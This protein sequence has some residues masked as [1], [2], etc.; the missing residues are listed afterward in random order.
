MNKPK[1]LIEV[2]LPLEAINRE[3]AREKSIRH[4][5]PSTLHLWWARRPL[6]A[7]RAVIFAQMV[8]DP[9]SRPDLFQTEEKQNKER[10]RLFKII[11]DLVKWE[12]MNDEDLLEKARAEI[13]KYAPNGEPPPLFDPFAGGGSIPLEAQRLGLKALAGDLNPVAVLINKA[14][15]EIPPRFAGRPPV[16]PEARQKGKLKVWKGAAGLAEDV[17]YYGRWMREEAERRIGHFYPKYKITEELLEKRPDLKKQGLK[18]GD[19]LTVIAWLWART[20][21]CPNPACGA[22]MP[23]ISSLW[24]S[25][26]K[27]K[28]AWVEP[29]VDRSTAPPTIRFE[30]RTEGK[31]PNSPKIGR[32]AKFKCVAC[33]QISED[34]HI[35]KEFQEKRNEVQLMAVVAEGVRGRIYLPPTED[36][37]KIAESVNPTWKP[38]IEMNQDCKDLISGRGYGFK[39]WY[40]IFTDRQLTALTTFSD[41][42]AEARE[43]VRGDAVAAGLPD[44]GKPLREGGCGATAYA[45][46]VAT[47]LAL[48]IDRIADRNSSICSWDSSRD[49]VRNTFARQALP[50]TWDFAEANP[51]SSSTGNFLGAVEWVA[52]VIERIPAE[53]GGLAQQTDATSVKNESS[54]LVISVDPPYYDNIGY[55]DLSDFFYIW[56]RR[57][58]KEIYP[59]LFG[60]LLTPKSDELVATPYRFGGD[61]EKARKFFEEGLRRAFENLRRATHPDYPV[62]IYYAFKQ[63]ETDGNGENVST[64][65]ETM[66]ESLI[67]AGFQITGTWPLRT[68]LGN[69]TVAM[70][71]NALASSIV[72]VCR[73]RAENAPVT[74]RR[75]FLKELKR[76]LPKALKELQKGNIAPVDLAQASI[77]PGMAIFSRYSRVLE[78]DGSSMTVRTALA[79]I[80]QALDEYLAEQEAEY[81]PDTRWAV[82]W[83][84]QYGFSEGPYG[85]AETLSKAKNTSVSGLEEAGILIARAG[86]VRLL[87]REELPEDWDPQSDQRLTVW[88]IT[89]HL[90]RTMKKEGEPVAAKLLAKVGGL[91]EAARELAYRLYNICERKG[92]AKEAQEYNALIISWPELEKQVEEL[93]NKIPKQ[94]DLNI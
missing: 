4:G 47:Y 71:T 7:C 75:D 5:H 14:L 72:L 16:N 13:R 70:G 40:E 25:K 62:T 15:I 60:T 21:T 38:I 54:R 65:W 66:L 86:K 27:G 78:A 24:L 93:R 59:E 42:V 46:A 81:D 33:G 87:K 83:F 26:K 91:G 11:R 20:V 90:I 18:L 36:H 10:E 44:D 58:L 63:A 67:S 41:L 23:L 68:E 57:S 39:Y 9:G 28:E 32:G 56:L 30:V 29:I 37:V 61:R 53:V 92:W 74:T 17:R 94:G 49:N 12:N 84:E 6:A 34:Q 76:E 22:R 8:D 77:G 19:K 50:M 45:E 80:N 31:P 73:P 88:E 52:E 82:A 79:L 43:K 35:R 69:R 1:K 51:L 55:A 85:D 89:Q 3:A 2:A 64:G 48:A